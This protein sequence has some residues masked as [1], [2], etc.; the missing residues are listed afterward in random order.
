MNWLAFE[1]ADLIRAAETASS[2]EA[3]DGA[4]GKHVKVL[5][6]IARCRTAA[7]G[8]HFDECTPCGHRTTI[9]CNCK[10]LL[11][12]ELPLFRQKHGD[13]AFGPRFRDQITLCEVL[14]FEEEPYDGNGVR[15][16]NRI[17]RR[18]APKGYCQAGQPLESLRPTFP[19]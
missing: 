8:G 15:G 2:S 19:K 16:R 14:F 4:A 10:S 9:S 18:Q 7:L 6:A 1:V 17:M 5:R 12:G 11:Q 13:G 3:A